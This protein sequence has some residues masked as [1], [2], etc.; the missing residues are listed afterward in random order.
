MQYRYKLPPDAS[1]DSVQD[2]LMIAVL[3]AEGLHG[4]SRVR[5]DAWFELDRKARHCRVDAGTAVGQDIARIFESFLANEFGE[6]A[7]EVERD[8]GDSSSPARVTS[9]VETSAA[10][11]AA[12][13]AGS[14]P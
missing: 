10:T 9:S 12:H 5:L 4:R 3:A 14:L 7:Y 6:G 1:M 2:S 8:D 13:A 11:V